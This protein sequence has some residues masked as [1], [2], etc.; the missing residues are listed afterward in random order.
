MDYLDR[1]MNSKQDGHPTGGT[2][3]K[4][5]KPLYYASRL[6]VHDRTHE[7][8]EYCSGGCGHVAKTL[9]EERKALDKAIAAT[10]RELSSAE[11]SKN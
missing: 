4:C 1:S 9:Q 5:D 2:C 6:Q 7:E 8:V 3:P 10:T 11:P